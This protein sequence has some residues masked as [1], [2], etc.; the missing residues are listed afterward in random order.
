MISHY[1][2]WQHIH[3]AE[4]LVQFYVDDSYLLESL[5]NYVGKGLVKGDGCIVIATRVHREALRKN[6]QTIGINETILQSRYISLDAEEILSKFM[7]KNM[8][9]QHLFE[10]II[11]GTV[12]K[13]SRPSYNV[14]AYGEMVALLW[15]QGNKKG[16]IALEQMWNILA[17]KISFSLFCAYPLEVFEKEKDEPLFKEICA[18]H[19]TIIPERSNY[20]DEEHKKFQDIALL[21]HNVWLLKKKRMPDKTFFERRTVGYSGLHPQER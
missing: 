19:T 3:D 5:V 6:L 10:K 8:P 16:A 17:A 21:Q 18:A 9:D 11:A 4:H 14:R 15:K 20:T 2:N 1:S 12:K 13:I 7:V